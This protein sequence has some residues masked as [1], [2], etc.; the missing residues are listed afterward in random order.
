VTFHRLPDHL[1]RM[2]EAA[3]QALSYVEG[4]EK[5]DFMED[6]R[7]QQAVVLNLIL[8]GEESTKILATYPDFAHA[9]TEIPWRS[10]KGMRNRIAHG[11]Y[12]I[13]MDTVWD[14]VQQA[15]PPLV[16]QLQSIQPTHDEPGHSH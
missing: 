13:N 1:G 14:T 5:P 12:E 15:L 9:H 11:Y 10:M 6:R 2:L 16:I 3:Q 7:T 8:I 4:N